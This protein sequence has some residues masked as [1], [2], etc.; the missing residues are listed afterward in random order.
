MNDQH[1]K[2]NSGFSL[3]THHIEVINMKEGSEQASAAPEKALKTASSV[4]FL[5]QA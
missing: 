5:A 3:I 1:T 4:K 2:S